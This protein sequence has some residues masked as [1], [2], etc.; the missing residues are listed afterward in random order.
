MSALA[1]ELIK[2]CIRSKYLY[3]DLGKCGLTDE[4]VAEGTEFDKLLRHCTHLKTLILSSQ[5]FERGKNGEIISKNS[6]NNSGVNYFNTHPPALELLVGLTTLICAGERIRQSKQ[7][8]SSMQFIANLRSLQSLD[9]SYNQISE[10]KGLD[11]LYN[12]KFL[13]FYNNQITEIKRLD[14]L[15]KL[16]YLDFGNNRISEIKGL[17]KL[18]NLNLLNIYNNQITE[19]KGLDKLINLNSLDISNN[20]I[21]EIKG[22]D[23]L[24]NL[25]SLDISKNQITEIK[26]LDKL[27][28][29]NSLRIY[30][31]QIN[32]IKGV[33]NL[34]NLNSLVISNNQITEIKGLENLQKLNSLNVSEN[35]IKEIKGLNNLQNLDSLNIGN[36]QI[37]EIKGL[38]NLQSL[39]RLNISNNQITELKGF[40]R[41]LKRDENPLKIVL[42]E[43]L[44][45]YFREINIGGNPIVTPPMAIV[46]QGNEA[47]LDFYE[48][49]KK[50]QLKPLNECKVIIV[51]D[52]SVG[53]TSLMKRVVFNTFN[54]DEKTTHGINKLSWKDVKNKDGD[55][56]TVNMWDFGGQ[57]LQHSLH[58]FFFSERVLYILVVS[59]RTCSNASYWLEQID[60]LGGDSTIMVVYNAKDEK[61]TEASFESIYYELQKKHT[62]LASSSTVDCENGDG[63]EVFRK[64]LKEAILTLPDLTTP[65]PTNWFNIKTAI[66][67]KVK[68]SQDNFYV[69][70]DE[71]KKICIANDYPDEE[72]QKR[73]LVQLDQIGSIVFFDR[74]DVNYLQV[75]NPEWITTGAYAIL[76]SSITKAKNGYLTKDDL[77]VIFKDELEIFADEKIKIRY[78]ENDIRY[79]IGLMLEYNLCQTNPYDTN[80]SYLVPA[81]LVGVPTKDYTI[82]KE[83]GKHYRFEFDA[84]FEMLIIHRFIARNLAKAKETDFWQSG[85]LIKDDGSETFA[86]V[87]TDLYSK[88]I[89]FWISGNEIRGFWESIR[90]DMKEICKIYKNFTPS[91]TVLYKK[92]GKQAFLSY[93]RMLTFLRNNIQNTTLDIS[94]TEI[95]Q[96][97][98][99]EVLDNFE[100]KDIIMEKLSVM[101]RKLEKRFDSTDQ[102]L[103]KIDIQL[104]Q[105]N[106]MILNLFELSK[107]GKKDLES[108]LQKIDTKLDDTKASELLENINTTITE[109]LGILPERFAAEWKKLNTKAAVEVEIK[110]KLKWKIPIIPFILD[111]ENEFSMDMKK[112]A[113][114]LREFV[115]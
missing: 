68:L 59:P 114:K 44:F 49:A 55:T 22:L 107:D 110:S 30:S 99:L 3:L 82:Y 93:S 16:N 105:Q 39:D 27:I 13:D 71:Y 45:I 56:I 19:I 25:N 87:E 94:E 6:I 42:R 100:S 14:N 98:I 32:E 40:V 72:K 76:T 23:K 51:G 37:E 36:N 75:L 77:K 41:F 33:D 9:L 84:P 81:T 70:Y 15:N 73:L 43:P 91:E 66:E 31:N 46:E 85:I 112:V 74:P 95:M 101:D 88:H 53:K 1:I 78:T 61:D 109:N 63:I 4:L 10:I 28:N 113:K 34:T 5:W 7:G 92:D 62:H 47:I 29:L 12:L 35:E 50:H 2:K 64:E 26:E 17:D 80:K 65:Y 103:N 24:I 57:H 83:A 104:L 106:E 86:L 11:Y 96:V 108:I 60:K 8:I 90:R 69:H 54:P 111:Y 115:F 97:D 48:Q 52:G 67:E 89:N 58:Q 38:D 21:T 102:Q 18:I 79:I 20:Q